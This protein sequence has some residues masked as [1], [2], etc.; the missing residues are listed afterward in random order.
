[1][2]PG[3]VVRIKDQPDNQRW[4]LPEMKNTNAWRFAQTCMEYGD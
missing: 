4:Q 2:K 3:D 1:M